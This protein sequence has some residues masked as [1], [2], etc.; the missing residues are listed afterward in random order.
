VVFLPLFS[1]LILAFGGHFL[2]REAGT[3]LSV[4]FL[5]ITWLLHC[6]YFMK[7]ILCKLLFLLIVINYID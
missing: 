5:F 4:F 2:G 7:Y 3:F 6:L 1:S